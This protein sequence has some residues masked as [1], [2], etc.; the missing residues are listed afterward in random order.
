MQDYR[1]VWHWSQE[2]L[3]TVRPAVQRALKPWW[4]LARNIPDPVLREQAL[5]SL[6]SK[7]FHC[8]GGAVLAA[9]SRDPESRVF[10]FLIPYQILCDYLD[11]VTDRGPSTDPADLRQLHQALLDALDPERPVTDIYRLHPQVDDGGYTRAL[12]HACHLALERIP[13]YVAVEEDVHRLAL[14]Y[15]DLQ[16]LKHGPVNDR[17]H[18]L[19]LWYQAL[20]GP[21]FGLSWWEFGAAA[22]STLGLFALLVLALETNPLAAVRDRVLALY[23]PWMGALHILLDYYI[24]QTEDQI[25]GDLNFVSY[26]QSRKAIADRLSHIYRTTLEYTHA[27]AD[28]PF[29]RYVAQGLLGF[30]LAD[31]KVG[32]HLGGVPI[33]LLRRGGITSVGVYLAARHGRSP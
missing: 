4:V 22:G 19:D 14:Y 11:T 9:P 13:S 26:Y 24:D 2:Y 20:D 1:A 21:R 25:G 27:L 31:P 33:Q 23:F 10:A 29:H 16:V 8:E 15:I 18:Q 17:V 30:Y 5:S 28:G 3:N 7:Q 32:R 6:T 12:I